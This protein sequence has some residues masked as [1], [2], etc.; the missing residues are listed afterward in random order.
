M[1]LG[2]SQ[3][4]TKRVRVFA[5]RT[6]ILSH[7]PTKSCAETGL[8]EGAAKALGEGFKLPEAVK[9]LGLPD[10]AKNLG[11]GGNFG[12]YVACVGMAFA[13][14]TPPMKCMCAVAFLA[15]MAIDIIGG[16]KKSN[17]STPEAPIPSPPDAAAR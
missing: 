2:V 3:P 9:N 12:K 5:A 16:G 11:G 14:P 6:L 15:S 8:S 10:A 1:G 4:R 7:D 13:L 17:P